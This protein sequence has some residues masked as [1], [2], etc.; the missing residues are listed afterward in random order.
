M[1][2]TVIPSNNSGR[3]QYKIRLSDVPLN[4]GHYRARLFLSYPRFLSYTG[5]AGVGLMVGTETALYDDWNAEF[6]PPRIDAHKFNTEIVVPLK[7]TQDTIIEFSDFFDEDSESYV[8]AQ[9]INPV[10]ILVERKVAD[11]ELTSLTV[12]SNQIQF[13]TDDELADGAAVTLDCSSI[14]SKHLLGPNGRRIFG[15][16]RVTKED[17]ETYSYTVDHYSGGDTLY[18]IQKQYIDGRYSGIKY[19]YGSNSYTASVWEA[20]YYECNPVTLVKLTAETAQFIYDDENNGQ[21]AVPM[22]A[23]DTVCLDGC[24]TKVIAVDGSRVIVSAVLEDDSV[25]NVSL[26]YCP[27]TPSKAVPVNWPSVLVDSDDAFTIENSSEYDHTENTLKATPV[28]D[29]YFS[30]NEESAT[31]N[32]SDILVCRCG[33]VDGNRVD[34]VSCMQF[35]SNTIESENAVAEL[36]LYVN[37]MDCSEAT[38]VLYQMDSAG[39]SPL[40]DYDIASQ[41]ITGIPIGSVT[42]TN[43]AMKHVNEATDIPSIDCGD[44]GNQVNIPIDSEVLSDWLSGNAVYSPSIAIKV[45]GDGVPT[46]SFS[47]SDCGDAAKAPYILITGGEEGALKPEPFDIV[48]SA[49]TVDA[50][51]ILKIIPVDG[52]VNTFGN[53][54]FNNKVMIGE[55]VAP[56]VAGGPTYLDVYVPDVHG[57]S[58]VMVYRKS[59]GSSADIPLTTDGTYIYVKSNTIGKSVKLA[60][61]KEPGVI[62]PSRVNSS[63]LYNRD[64]GFNNITEVTDESSLIQNVYSILLTNPGERLFSQNFGTGITERLFKLGSQAE[65]LALLQECIQKVNLYEPRVHIDGDQSS[66][67]FDDSENRYYLLLCC[68]LPS[69]RT[70]FIKLPFKNRGRMV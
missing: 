5:D 12:L 24:N 64:M 35:A 43:P 67:E 55:G 17:D 61:K 33:E 46:V 53:S 11:I 25:P 27:R 9:R 44:Y 7:K 14:T 22:Q 36:V 18:I 40:M 65:G 31:H 8:D 4:E 2:V 3:L 30:V 21:R 69:A 39:W 10:N 16:Y 70:E 38:I 20:C 48:V 63:A 34:S 19:N 15:T 26:M 52:T 41:H 6:R 60:E 45:V 37:S 58:N 66:C 57:S 42:L 50:G 1:Q 51:Q 62:D 54:I 59:R 29:T 23:D 32:R 56:I 13:T 28:M 68:V 49:T 47:S